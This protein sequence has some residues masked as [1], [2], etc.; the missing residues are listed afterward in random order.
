[1]MTNSVK[2]VFVLS[3]IV[4]LGGKL[5]AKTVFRGNLTADNFLVITD[6]AGVLAIILGIV[7]FVQKRRSSKV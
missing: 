1:M 4:W 5:L 6:I 7:L 2:P 3:L